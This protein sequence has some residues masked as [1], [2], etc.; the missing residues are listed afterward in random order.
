[1][2]K[3]SNNTGH[4]NKFTFITLKNTITTPLTAFLDYKGYDS[5]KLKLPQL[6]IQHLK[7]QATKNDD[8]TKRRKKT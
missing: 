2:E 7:Y 4:W 5:W 3:A 8:N 6:Q 1:M